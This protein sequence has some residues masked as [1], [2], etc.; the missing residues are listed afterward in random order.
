MLVSIC[1]SMCMQQCNLFFNDVLQSTLWCHFFC[2]NVLRIRILGVDISWVGDNSTRGIYQVT[3]KLWLKIG[4]GRWGLEGKIEHAAGILKI[5]FF[6]HS[7]TYRPICRFF[8]SLSFQVQI[9][10]NCRCCQPERMK[11]GNCRCFKE[12]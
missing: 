1:M 11:G 8:I 7:L 5:T 12:I 6:F 2:E 4:D 10:F 9:T 3:K